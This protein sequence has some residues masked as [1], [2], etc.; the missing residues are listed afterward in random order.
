MPKPSQPATSPAMP[1][2]TKQE[3]YDRRLDLW[4][5]WIG[6][7]DAFQA[8]R[9]AQRT[10][11]MR[12][13][14]FSRILTFEE[15]KEHMARLGEKEPSLAAAAGKSYQKILGVFR[16][17][18]AQAEGDEHLVKYYVR[19]L[20]CNKPW[21]YVRRSYRPLP[22]RREEDLKRLARALIAAAAERVNVD[23]SV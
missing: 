17:P 23:M 1:R 15:F 7:P 13:Y 18:W 8:V 11:L 22:S 16:L 21:F 4:D 6:L 2:V 5:L 3:Q 12:W 14:D 10:D 19:S 9:T 20:V